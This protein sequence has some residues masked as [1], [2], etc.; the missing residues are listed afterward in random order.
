MTRILLVRHGEA[1]AEWG[2]HE[3]PG[4]SELGWEQAANSAAEL[5]SQVDSQWQLVSSPKMRA[6]ETAQPLVDATGLAV[7]IDP[8]YREVPAPVPMAQRKQWLR[9]FMQQQWADQPD[10]LWRWRRDI[11]EALSVL[12]RPTVIFTHFLVINAVVSEAQERGEVLCFWPDNA[13]ITEL[14]LEQGRLRLESLGRSLQ[15]EVN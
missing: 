11:V 9:R 5:A 1:A 10:D 12:E 8:V 4:L 13:S 2:Q 7:R 6:R 15:T 3:D 14:H